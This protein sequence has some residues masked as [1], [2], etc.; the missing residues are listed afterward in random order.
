M[1]DPA[2]IEVRLGTFVLGFA[3]IEAAREM[4]RLPLA[5]GLPRGEIALW[6]DDVDRVHETLTAKGIRCISAPHD[7]LG[8]RLRAA[9]YLDPEGNHIQVVAKV[10]EIV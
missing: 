2:H 9:W 4:H 1:G 10:N 6:S 3:S 5:P 8:G 7:F